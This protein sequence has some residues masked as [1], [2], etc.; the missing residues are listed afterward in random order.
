M[1]EM[2]TQESC[3]QS[4]TVVHSHYLQRLESEGSETLLTESQVPH[5]ELIFTWK[6]LGH[7]FI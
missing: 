7:A 2:T 3:P 1:S 4:D 6:G 5:Y